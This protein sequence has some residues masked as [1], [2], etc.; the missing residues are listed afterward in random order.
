MSYRNTL[1]TYG[2]V[3]KFFH[4]LVFVLLTCM[5]VYGYFLDD[6]PKPYQGLSYNIHKLIGLTIFVLMLLRALWAM[7]NPKPLLPAN[8]PA[9]QVSAARIVHLSLYLTVIAMP[10]AGWVGSCAAGRPPHIGSFQL[11]LPIVQDKALSHAAFDTHGLLALIIIGLL[12]LHILAAFYHELICKD[13]VLRRM[14]PWNIMNH[15]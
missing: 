3:A 6:V 7:T 4:W 15:G 5:L 14:L 9:W 10:I 13:N 8:T 2:R 11:N 1:E 12:S